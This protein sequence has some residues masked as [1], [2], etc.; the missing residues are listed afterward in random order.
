LAP[1]VFLGAEAPE[2]FYH[3]PEGAL[4]SVSKL[5]WVGSIDKFYL[6]GKITFMLALVGSGEYLPPMAPVD[7]YLL[8]LLPR[9]PDVVCLPTAAGTEGAARLGYWMDLGMAYFT[10]L[11]VPVESL[12]V[13]DRA[14]AMNPAYAERVR[15]ASF[16]YLS[17][18]RPDYLYRSL[19]GTPLWEA[20]L[21]VH[22]GG[23]VVAGCSAGAMI[24]GQ[25]I[26]G[27]PRMFG[28][29]P[30]F[31]LLPGCVI[32]PHFDEIPSL[33]LRP[34]RVISTRRNTMLGIEGDTALVVRS[35]IWEACGRGSVTV[36]GR[37]SSVRYTDGQEIPH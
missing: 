37:N 6:T 5:L 36:W 16:V 32:V 27:F 19:E 29:Q 34:V 33:M 31:S 30:G 23:G 22:L 2:E 7:Q 25:C 26:P 1:Y 24:M 11:G 9:S 8:G 28:W 13:S 3:S 15:R 20:I 35:N 10:R 12:P 17:G 14:G 18:G 21:A 4:L